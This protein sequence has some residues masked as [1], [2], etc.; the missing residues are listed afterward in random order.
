MR[1]LSFVI[2][3]TV[4]LLTALSCTNSEKD[5]LVG[6][7]VPVSVDS[8]YI[9]SYKLSNADIKSITTEN[10]IEFTKDGKVISVDGRDTSLGTYN[11]DEKTKTLVMAGEGGKTLKFSIDMQGDK[12]TAGNDFGKMTFTKK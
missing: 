4:P 3:F 5:R 12:M 2:L 10:S 1:N 6:K 11:Y 8:K 9:S 7:W